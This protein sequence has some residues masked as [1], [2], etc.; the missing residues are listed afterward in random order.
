MTNEFQLEV[1][2][3][4]GAL[5]VVSGVL[6]TILGLFAL[7]MTFA[8]TVA[9]M[10][11]FGVLL[12]IAG[13]VE[14][15]KIFRS[16]DAGGAIIHCVSAVLYALVGVYLIMNPVSSAIGLT[17]VAA[18][19]FFTAGMIKLASSVGVR[20]YSNRSGW[21]AFG[22]VVDIALAVLIAT[23]WPLSGLWVIGLFVAIDLLFH[24]ISWIAIGA[25]SA[26]TGE[27]ASQH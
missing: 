1:L 15:I 9:S 26:G 7:I 19:F 12:L 22:G 14:G 20:T 16:K 17:L 21:L 3:K 8:T 4:H 25:T 18:T 13:I 11:F 10:I 24:G 2:E 5:F 23:Q 6:L 27:A